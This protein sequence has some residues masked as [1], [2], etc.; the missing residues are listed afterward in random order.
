VADP[1]EEMFRRMSPEDGFR[2]VREDI[3]TRH[4]TM[5]VA[6]NLALR[7]EGEIVN[8]FDAHTGKDATVKLWERRKPSNVDIGASHR[9]EHF[10]EGFCR[11]FN[12]GGSWDELNAILP[13]LKTFIKG[14]LSLIGWHLIDTYLD[15][16]NNWTHIFIK[17][18][19]DKVIVWVEDNFIDFK[20]LEDLLEENSDDIV[21]TSRVRRAE[22]VQPQSRALPPGRADPKDPP[23]VRK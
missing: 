18:G 15:T 8:A 17:D 23:E 22:S 19:S 3:P 12:T 5:V 4:P 10:L 21:W 20:K 14:G 16:D 9:L 11:Y 13:S 6:L 2:I 7:E 1:V